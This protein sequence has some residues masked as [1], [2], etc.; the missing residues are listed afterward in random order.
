MLKDF[1]SNIEPL[2]V[3]CQYMLYQI[4]K[5]PQGNKYINGIIYFEKPINREEMRGVLRGCIPVNRPGTIEER[6]RYVSDK[7]KRID[8]PYT[9][10]L[11]PVEFTFD[12]PK[13]SPPAGT[14][15][16]G[17]SG[18]T[19][20][21]TKSYAG[22]KK[23]GFSKAYSSN[24]KRSNFYKRKID[25]V[26]NS[27]SPS[28]SPVSLITLNQDSPLYLVYVNLKQQYPFLNMEIVDQRLVITKS[29]VSTPKSNNST[30]S[31]EEIFLRDDP[32]SD[33]LAIGT[34]A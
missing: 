22:F 31:L 5:D 25:D 17:G 14:M 20:P 2:K 23:G 33:L 19:T 16:V 6:V 7:S 27:V 28:K 8:G 32:T 3:K 24:F 34:T 1:K 10:G 18:K 9:K 4:Q 29:A 12:Y 26:S 21:V 30:S 13:Y 11:L 15:G